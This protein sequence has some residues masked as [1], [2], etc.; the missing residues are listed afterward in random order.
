MDM[1]ERINAAL[2]EAMKAK[3]AGRLSTLRLIS[4]AIK[5]REIAARGDGEE[6]VIGDDEVLAILGKMVK[7]RQES[8][9]QYEE[10]GRLELAEK[11]RGEISVIED[12]LPRQLDDAEV[13]AAITA[14]M[15]E[16]GA[17]SIRDMGKVM[18]A[19]KAKYTG[20]M[21]FGAVGPM[22]KAK[23]G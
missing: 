22:V 23:L 15:A 18:G 11:E 8:A 6:S 13:D 3:D 14:A 9:R 19:L 5:D 7:Q 20:Q 10:G 4:A 12:F 1:R 16:V 17:E 2:K 21:D